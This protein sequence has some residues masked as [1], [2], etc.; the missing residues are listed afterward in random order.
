MRFRSLRIPLL[1]V[2]AIL[3]VSGCSRRQ[4]AP[5]PKP[6]PPAPQVPAVPEPAPQ[7]APQP[8]PEP[9][10]EPTP[11]PPPPPE[12]HSAKLDVLADTHLAT[13]SGEETD[14]YGGTSSL[15]IKH[16][17][18]YPLLRFDTSVIPSNATVKKA[19]I[20]VH[21]NDP[22]PDF[23]L[24]HVSVSTVPT[25]WVEGDEGG[26]KQGEHDIACARW[27]GPRSVKWGWK[28]DSDF[29][30]SVFGNAGNVTSLARARHKGDQWWEIPTS[31]RVVEAMRTDQPGGI[32]LCDEHIKRVGKYANIWLDSRTQA[33]G[34]FAPYM[35]A[36]YT[37]EDTTPP[38]APRVS[39]IKSG[40][41]PGAV[42]IAVSCGGD[43]GD[44]GTALGFDIAAIDAAGAK[45]PVERYS[46]PRPAE[47]GRTVIGILEGLTPGAEYS[48][49]ITA[50]DEAG[51]RSAPIRSSAVTAE[52]DQ[53][54]KLTAF[55]AIPVGKGQPLSAGSLQ[56]YAVDNMIKVDPVAGAPDLAS[57]N[58]VY[59]GSDHCV[60]IFGARGEIIGINLVLQQDPNAAPVSV[61]V[62]PSALSTPNGSAIDASAY[63]LH[64]VIYA[65]AGGRYY[66]EVTPADP[67]PYDLPS[68]DPVISGQSNQMVAVDLYVPT[69]AAPGE[70]TGKFDISAGGASAEL[71]VRLK[72]YP[73][74]IPDEVSFLVE[75]NAYGVG[76]K[77]YFYATHRLAHLNRLGYNVLSYGHRGNSRQDFVPV[78][79][80][81][82]KAA[83]VTDWSGYD[84]WMDPIFSGSLFNDLPR[85]GIPVPHFYLPFFENW[86]MPL[87][88]HYTN[89]ELADRPESPSN[90]G[91]DAWKMNFSRSAPLIEDALDD[92][93][94]EGNKAIAA[95]FR[96]HFEEKGWTRTQHQ[97]FLNCKYYFAS[98]SVSYWTLDE[99]Q[100]AHDW[101]ALDFIYRTF[102][103]PFKGS[104]VNIVSR[105]DVSRPQFQGDMMNTTPNLLIN[106]SGAYYGYS[107]LMRR[108]AVTQGFMP[109]LYGGGSGVPSGNNNAITATIVKS[110]CMGTTGC[111]PY[112]TSFSGS[113]EWTAGSD[114]RQVYPGNQHGY[115]ET[116]AGCLRMAAMRR[117]Q[118][119]AE[120]L[121]LLAAKPGWDR[122][123]L[124]RSV[125]THLDLSGRLQSRNADDPGSVSFAGVSPADFAALR[126]AVLEELA[127]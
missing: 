74:V 55:A 114:L 84:S 24:N 14:G 86:P 62:V 81:E 38:S 3:P 104:K 92:G 94:V 27:A 36:V 57:G 115:G 78:T 13:Y 35:E 45:T 119:D 60:E 23:F 113:N 65:G 42:T 52:S 101:R 93:W 98:G 61:A 39:E 40:P 111:M 51:N 124:S 63:R 50:Y 32:I 103:E 127:R 30:G 72:V 70:Y 99:P 102:M 44:A 106:V 105:A 79:E 89:R 33:G 5:A 7:P 2:V 49:E 126:K 59:N 95:E 56:V 69:T 37:V 11:P 9:V 116:V 67:G 77:N 66:G 120:L 54:P 48:F 71:P 4:P 58:H 73:A 96:R 29:L 107:P 90:P 26:T 12:E 20:F 22:D 122:W 47:S 123:R 108:Y 21:I 109:W 82:G 88:A 10:V 110:W 31:G 28:N 16:H 75:L 76:D 15:K 83:R 68:K 91:Y 25:F 18:N 117:G 41:H 1:F 6:S 112:W 19:S 80:G 97:V 46:I 43:D 118:L 8:A 125:L 121:N 100:G 85:K 87:H 53:P 34:S 17:E 64:R